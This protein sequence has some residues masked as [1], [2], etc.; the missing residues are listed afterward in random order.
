MGNHKVILRPGNI[1]R[2]DY[3]A[4]LDKVMGC[5]DKFSHSIQRRITLL[6]SLRDKVAFES[7]LSRK[8]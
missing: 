1:E 5:D 3:K 2:A 7:Y 4:N 8:E 6:P